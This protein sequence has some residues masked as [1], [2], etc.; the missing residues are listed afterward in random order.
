M[1][2][3]GQATYIHQNINSFLA[4]TFVGSFALCVG[5]IV[6]QAALGTN[7][8]ADFIVQ[9]EVLRAAIEY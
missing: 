8:I 6:W 5:L 9:T 1:I 3:L 4:L 2:T 7:P